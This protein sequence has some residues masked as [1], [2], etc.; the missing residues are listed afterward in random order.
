VGH[1]AA[2]LAALVILAGCQTT[3]GSFCDI[4]RP[5]RLT[6]QTVAALSDAE[7]KQVLALNRKGQKLCG[8][9]P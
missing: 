9:H 3:G 6:K 5:I 4:A 7:V 8:W 1:V 2:A